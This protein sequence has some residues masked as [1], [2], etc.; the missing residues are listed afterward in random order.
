M[1]G[2][3]SAAL[4]ELMLRR[5]GSVNPAVTP[6]QLFELYSI[7]AHDRGGFDEV[8]GSV[9]G[10]SKQR[11]E[12][13]DVM[14]SKIVPHI[15]RARVV[16]PCRGLDQIASG[17]WIVFR[18][19]KVEPDYLRHYL[20]SDSFHRQF[21]STVAGVGGSLL[22]ARP[23]AVAN[24]VVP[25]P[26]IE[27]QR[28]IAAI[29]DRADAL[30]LLADR[31]IKLHQR[32][33]ASLVACVDRSGSRRVRLGEVARIIRGASPRPAGDPRYFGGPIPWLKISDITASPGRFVHRVK[34]GV[35]TEGRDRSVLIPAG[36][37]ILT[38][39]ATVGV[40]KV[41][42]LETCIHDG[43]L[44]FTDLDDSVD[45]RFLYGALLASRQALVDLAP[46]GTQK[47]LNTG[48]VKGFE[49]QLPG[50]AEQ[51]RFGERLEQLEQVAEVSEHRT[52][53]LT[54]LAA[55]LQTRAFSGRL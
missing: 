46:Q 24:I 30:R 52:A 6:D 16:G 18:T 15:R 9:V 8:L 1:K 2:W 45:R 37:L 12:P 21:M 39:S 43:F 26:P 42:A 36:T 54:S 14:V 34:E 19:S 33:L 41:M 22:R 10:S 25:L 48:I 32:L 13:G 29:L 20:V 5:G 3:T 31:E 35:T 11:V 49:I 4:G 40:A 51:R 53:E 38:N 7:P 50:L 23:A 28:R 44:A 55:S 27:E 17:E 47:N